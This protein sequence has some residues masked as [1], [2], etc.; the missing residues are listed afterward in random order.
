M[1]KN[2]NKFLHLIPLTH[3]IK[4][5]FQNFDRVT[6]FTLLTPNFMQSFR[7]NFLAVSEIS[8]DGQTDGRTDGQGRL[9]WTP[10]GR[11]MVQ[12]QKTV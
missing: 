10:M 6:F 2:H 8:K 11:P 4:I 5:F 3:Q 12:N 1:S 7:K 9:L